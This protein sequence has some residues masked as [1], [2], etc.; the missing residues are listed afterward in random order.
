MITLLES[1]LPP[2]ADSQDMTFQSQCCLSSPVLGGD[3]TVEF[4]WSR[5]RTGDCL[6]ISPGP[7]PAQD[8]HA[9]VVHWRGHRLGYLMPAYKIAPRLHHG[10]RFRARISCLHPMG[11]LFASV[12][13]L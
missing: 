4:L 9:V 13:E 5:M 7:V 12:F 2:V 11:V 3:G 8:A 10:E 1:V 6:C